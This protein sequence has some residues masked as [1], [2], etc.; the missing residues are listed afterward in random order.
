MS[1]ALKSSSVLWAA[2]TAM[3]ASCVPLFGEIPQYPLHYGRA[4]IG[5]VF[6]DPVWQ[7]VIESDAFQRLANVRFLGAIDYLVHPN[8]VPG[9]RRHTRFQH[10]LGVGVLALDASRTLDLDAVETRHVVVAAL[11]HDLGHAPLSHSLEPVFKR[12][13]GITHHAAGQQILR[14]E[15][16][17]GRSLPNILAAHGLDLERVLALIS[18]QGDGPAAALFASPINID[19]IEAIARSYS[20]ASGHAVETA[21]AVVLRASLRREGTRDQAV[22]DQFW[23]LKNVVYKHIINGRAGLLADY[24]ARCYMEQH[25]DAFAVDSY[26]LD[27]KVLRRQHGSLFSLLNKARSLTNLR[28]CLSKMSLDN[29]VDAPSRCF[30]I[31]ETSNDPA[32]LQSRYRQSKSVRQVKLGELIPGRTECHYRDDW[33]QAD[34]EAFNATCSYQL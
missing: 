2:G 23:Q 30:Y 19:T 33:L 27:E 26:F 6:K 20:Y 4:D 9:H 8:G 13:F 22:L 10:S 17:V 14:G 25:I 18:G 21:P 34:L 5:R 29:L 32:D 12:R 15:A 28:A 31:D 1:A 3:F 16:P 11:T 24:L 7:A